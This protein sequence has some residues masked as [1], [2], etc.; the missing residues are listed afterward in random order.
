MLK[1]KCA[2]S[3][4]LGKAPRQLQRAGWLGGS[5]CLVSSR[6][7][8]TALHE[9]GEKVPVAFVGQEGR[10]GHWDWAEARPRGDGAGKQGQADG[11]L[12]RSRTS[13]AARG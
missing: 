11:F 10:L 5:T 6:C 8:A 12:C 7:M 1:G 2:F 13:I 3:E 9:T 4:P